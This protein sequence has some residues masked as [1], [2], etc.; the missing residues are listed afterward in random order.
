MHYCRAN[1]AQLGL[2]KPEI[3]RLS[4]VQAP[5]FRNVVVSTHQAL[6]G[7]PR[8]KWFSEFPPGDYCTPLDAK[9]QRLTKT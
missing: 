4:S 9:Q 2:K 8:T 6:L 7:T 3:N 5:G 1:N